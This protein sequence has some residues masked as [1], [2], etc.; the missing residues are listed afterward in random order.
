MAPATVMIATM[1]CCSSY[2]LYLVSGYVL[3]WHNFPQTF[4]KEVMPMM[5]IPLLMCNVP[6]TLLV[7]FTIWKMAIVLLLVVKNELDGMPISLNVVI[8]NVC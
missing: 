8:F 5:D 6:F 1:M 3:C 7:L 4:Q 2:C